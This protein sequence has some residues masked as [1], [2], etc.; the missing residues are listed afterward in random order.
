MKYLIESAQFENYQNELL[1]KNIAD[2][3]DERVFKGQPKFEEFVISPKLG[4]RGKLDIVFKDD[5]EILDII[6]LKSSKKDYFTKGIQFYHE[7]QVVAYCMMVMLKQKK[8]LSQSNPSVIY[9][10]A[11]GGIETNA[12]L[13]FQTFSNVAKFRN[14]L[15]SSNIGLK[16]PNEIDEYHAKYKKKCIACSNNDIYKN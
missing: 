1:L 11:T 16:L 3:T 4:L 2:W 7:L 14:I 6:E 8:P 10:K 12:T 13:N 9:S 15:L 5:S